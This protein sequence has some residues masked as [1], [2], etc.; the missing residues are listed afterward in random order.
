LDTQVLVE[1]IGLVVAEAVV[2]EAL[3]LMMLVVEVELPKF[4]NQIK[5]QICLLLIFLHMSGLVQDQVL[6]IQDQQHD[7]LGKTLVLVEVAL[8]WVLVVQ[9]NRV[10]MVD[11]EWF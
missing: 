9:D 7:L 2:L 11:L 6:R 5:V 3:V 1:L 8:V 10:A 4:P